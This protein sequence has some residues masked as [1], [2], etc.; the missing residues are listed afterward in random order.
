MAKATA[1]LCMVHHMDSSGVPRFRGFSIFS[2]VPWG[3]TNTRTR[4]YTIYYQLEAATYDEAHQQ[5]LD[6]CRDFRPFRW[7]WPWVDPSHEAH[8][9]RFDMERALEVD[10][11]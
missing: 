3:L 8:Q 1:Y 4:F 7:I 5:L 10:G 9:N 6:T 11:G 2:E